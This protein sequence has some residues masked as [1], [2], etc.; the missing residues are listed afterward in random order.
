MGCVLFMCLQLKQDDS[1]EIQRLVQQLG[2]VMGQNTH[3]GTFTSYILTASCE[4]EHLFKVTLPSIIFHF[5][6]LL[7]IVRLDFC[8]L[9]ERNH[10][11]IQLWRQSAPHRQS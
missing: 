10:H 5:V 8:P 4:G 2:K 7:H 3:L 1:L 9:P 11:F 6:I